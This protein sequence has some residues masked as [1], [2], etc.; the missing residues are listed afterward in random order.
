MSSEPAPEDIDGPVL[1]Y[2]V[3]LGHWET[4]VE[5][6]SVLEAVEKGRRDFWEEWPQFYHDI[7]EKTWENFSVKLENE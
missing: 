6:R 1:R 3:K 2:R 5:A 7:M 4:Q